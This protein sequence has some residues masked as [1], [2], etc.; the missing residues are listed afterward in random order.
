MITHLL[1]CPVNILVGSIVPIYLSLSK[2]NFLRVYDFGFGWL[3][4][5]AD[6]FS[7]LILMNIMIQKAHSVIKRSQYENSSRSLK[8]VQVSSDFRG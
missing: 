3:E 7:V 5:S 4:W 8:N 6:L 1:D 2:A